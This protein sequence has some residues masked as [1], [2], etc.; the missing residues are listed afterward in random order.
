MILDTHALLWWLRDDERLSPRARDGIAH[1]QRALVS[2]ASAWEIAKSQ[3]VGKLQFR[4]WDPASL[5]ELL[6]TAGFEVLPVSL[7]H[8]LEAGRLAGPL[9]DPFDRILVA[10]C[11]VERLPIV[12]RDP[13]FREYGVEVIW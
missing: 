10:Q 13:V 3:R 7:T 6:E 11:R 8:G 5:P 4:S 2:A 9:T 1:A 12:S